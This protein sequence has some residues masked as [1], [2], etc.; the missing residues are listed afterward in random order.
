MSQ[1]D[2]R[3]S[4]GAGHRIFDWLTVYGSQKQDSPGKRGRQSPRRRHSEPRLTLRDLEDPSATMAFRSRERLSLASLVPY[5]RAW[6]SKHDRPLADDASFQFFSLEAEELPLTYLVPSETR[7]LVYRVIEARDEPDGWRFSHWQD[8]LDDSLDAYF[9]R[10]LTEAINSGATVG[11]MRRLVADH[12]GI[13]DP[14]RII[15]VARGGL[16]R[17][18]LL[19]NDWEVRQVRNWLCRWL[20]IDVN[21]RKMYAV[22]R[23]LGREYLHHPKAGCVSMSV[24]DLLRYVEDRLLHGV[25]RLGY[26]KSRVPF[27][28]ASL[29]REGR[30]LGRQGGEE[31]VWGATYTFDVSEEVAEAFSLEEAWLL[32]K[33]MTCNICV[34]DKT[35]VEMRNPTVR[36]EH[37]PTVCRDCVQS[38]LRTNIEGSKWRGLNCPECGEVLDY[39]DVRRCAS[40][41]MFE[42]YDYL[43]THDVL[44]GID[45]FRFCLSPSCKSGQMHHRDSECP[46]FRCH[47][48]AARHCVRH[49]VPWHHGMTCEEYDETHPE[50]RREETASEREKSATSATCP[51]CK[52]VC[53][54]YIGCNHITCPCGHEYCYLCLEPHHT[55]QHGLT[56]CRHK[57]DCPEY[58]NRF[59]RLNDP[60]LVPFRP[61]PPILP[62]PPVQA[63]NPPPLPRPLLPQPRGPLQLRPRIV[64]AVHPLDARPP[65]RPVPPDLEPFARLPPLPPAG[66]N[67]G[68][69]ERN[70]VDRENINRLD[71]GAGGPAG[72]DNGFVPQNLRPARHRRSRGTALHVTA[73]P[74]PGPARDPRTGRFVADWPHSG[75]SDDDGR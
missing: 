10:M 37:P 64:D 4:S 39:Q 25:H 75:G 28:E 48:C 42:R 19:G 33:E 24:Q 46:E 34:E 35:V 22:I 41:E 55:N 32:P 14:N 66:R 60:G 13:E 1:K 26:G 51:S 56:Y 69:T 43:M 72:G 16:R 52:R 15:L 67:G 71:A 31:V 61:V 27:E 62:V 36:C 30:S 9:T 3:R 7:E 17:G 70:D 20:S 57:P 63:V 40:K 49:D 38:W 11:Q 74:G 18:S 6:Y 68:A 50:R 44:N 12:M 2:R 53:H 8:R 21:P 54:K 59:H 29:S 47:A 23:G 73:A 5:M 65:R 45:E 58:N